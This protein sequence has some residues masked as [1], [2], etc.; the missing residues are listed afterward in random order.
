MFEK[1][2]EG[3]KGILLAIGKQLVEAFV[4]IHERAQEAGDYLVNWI[5]GILETCFPVL[6]LTSQD[7]AVQTMMAQANYIF[8]LNELISMALCWSVMWGSAM[9]YR[10]IKSWIPTVS[11]S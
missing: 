7:A 4:W 8:P 2:Y 9:T 5:F 6:D 11:G 3:L 10:A 1:L